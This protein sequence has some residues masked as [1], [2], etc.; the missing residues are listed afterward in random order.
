LKYL[1]RDVRDE[2]VTS[3]AGYDT[4]AELYEKI[5]ILS[6]AIVALA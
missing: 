5:K 3:G 6:D 1:P 2:Y 4:K